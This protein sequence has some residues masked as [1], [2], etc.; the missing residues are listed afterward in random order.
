[1][2]DCATGEAFFCRYAKKRR[3][4]WEQATGMH[5]LEVTPQGFR[6]VNADSALEQRRLEASASSSASSSSSSSSSS[7]PSS[8]STPGELHRSDVVDETFS[9]GPNGTCRFKDHFGTEIAFQLRTEEDM[10]RLKRVMCFFEYDA[11]VA[12]DLFTI[13]AAAASSEGGDADAAADVAALDHLL[14]E[15][16]SFIDYVHRLG[17]ALSAPPQRRGGAPRGAPR[18]ANSALMRNGINRRDAMIDL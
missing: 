7:F 5:V 14:L 2:L 10:R 8:P 9:F 15:D 16:P 4:S 11:A 3:G 17:Q 18:A 1:M 12:E 13:A 6:L